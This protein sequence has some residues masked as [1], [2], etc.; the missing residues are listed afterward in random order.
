MSRALAAIV[1]EHASA[2]DASR[3]LKGS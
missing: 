2:K 3:L 1:H